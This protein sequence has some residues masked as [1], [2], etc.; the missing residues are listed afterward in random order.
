MSKGEGELIE[1]WLD[2]FTEDSGDPADALMKIEGLTEKIAEDVGISAEA[3]ASSA[4]GKVLG[5]ISEV[6]SIEATKDETYA[7]S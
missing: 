6:D 5:V 4:L 7:E 2:F 3:T 1:Q